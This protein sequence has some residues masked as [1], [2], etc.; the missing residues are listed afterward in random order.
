MQPAFLLSEDYVAH[1]L[2]L[3]SDDEILA[4]LAKVMGTKCRHGRGQ[5]DCDCGE[6]LA[7]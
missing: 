2:R 1:S 4:I 3:V 7:E 6:Y 5:T